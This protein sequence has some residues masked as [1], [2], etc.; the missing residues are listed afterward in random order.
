[1]TNASKTT[2]T[3]S[4]SSAATSQEKQSR[5]TTNICKKTT[6]T[7]PNETECQDF[8]ST[9]HSNCV[10]IGKNDATS[11][12]DWPRP[13]RWVNRPK[14][15]RPAAVVTLSLTQRLGL[16]QPIPRCHH[17]FLKHTFG[18]PAWWTKS[19]FDRRNL[20]PEVSHHTCIR[21]SVFPKCSVSFLCLHGQGLFLWAVIHRVSFVTM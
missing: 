19:T 18:V 15:L 16:G 10:I 2:Y 9:I 14:S 3:D 1:M 20:W 5:K 17:L 21:I 4:K 11:G 6:K 13:S 8:S 7:L 12:W